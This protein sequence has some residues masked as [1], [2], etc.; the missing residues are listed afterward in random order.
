MAGQQPE[1]LLEF[2]ER[3]GE[4]ARPDQAVALLDQPFGL[5]NGVH[6]GGL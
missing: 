3:G 5:F 6:R 1:R 2:P 4:L